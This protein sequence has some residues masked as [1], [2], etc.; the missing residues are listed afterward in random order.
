LV[1]QSPRKK[2]VAA[3]LQEVAAAA[4]KQVIPNEEKSLFD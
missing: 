1:L 3:G 2:A 4:G